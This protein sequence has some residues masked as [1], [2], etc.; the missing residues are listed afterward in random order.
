MNANRLLSL[1]E[2]GEGQTLEFKES[3]SSGRRREG[4][5]T[6]VA[7][8]N[9]DGGEVLFGIDDGGRLRGAN[10]GQNTIEHFANEVESHTYPTLPVHLEL[11]EIAGKMVLVAETTADRPPVIG[12]YAHAAKSIDPHSAVDTADLRA[13]RR[14]GRVNQRVDFMWLRQEMPSDPKIRLNI[15]PSGP[16]GSGQLPQTVGAQVWIDLPCASAHFIE[17][18]TDPAVYEI[19][20]YVFD[21]PVPQREGDSGPYHIETTD[22]VELQL[23]DNAERIIGGQDQFSFCATYK[24]DFGLT[25]EVRRDIYVDRDESGVQLYPFVFTRRI[26]EFPPKAMIGR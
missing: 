11:V 12:F 14:V 18:S 3:L 1:I 26:K 2:G 13:F 16:A 8:A 10:V 24:D 21:L 19:G 9:R 22:S 17:L 20:Y 6:L 5:E 23:V 15:Y 4:I 7:F 25:W